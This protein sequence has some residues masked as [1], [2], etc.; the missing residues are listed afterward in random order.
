MDFLDAF[1]V[2]L[3]PGNLIFIIIGVISGIIVG[4]IPGLTAT[5]A[6]SLLLPFTFGLE[7]IPAL[8]M[9]MGIYCGSMF[10]GSITAILVRAPGT[11]GAAATAIE[12]YPLTVKGQGGK[13]IGMAAVASFI[14]GIFSAGVMIWLSPIISNFAL[15]FSYPEYFALAFFGLTIIFSVSG[16]SFLKG[17]ISGTI[18]LLLST[19]GL[20]YIIPHPRF[21]FGV[22]ELM[23]GFPLLPSVIG[24]FAVSEVFR[25]LEKS[26]EIGRITNKI[27]RTVPSLK[28]IKD[29][30]FVFLKSSIIGTL[31][32]ALPGAGA[33][34][35]SFVA[36]SEARR[37]SKQRDKYGTGVIEGIAACESAN[38]AVTGGAMIPMLTL[39]IPGDAV[40]AVLLGALTIQGLM[41]GPL[42][43]RDHLNIIRPLFAG[44]LIANIV[45]LVAG[46]A[47]ANIFARIATIRKSVLLPAIAIFSLVGAFA[48][49]S[50]IFHMGIAVGFGIMGYFLEKNGYPL[51]PI[52]L[53]IIL[54]PLAETSFRNSL[55]KSDGS[56]SI[57]FTRPISLVLIIIA[58]LSVV[59]TIYREIKAKK[60]V[61]E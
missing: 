14:G 3:Q 49:E 21:T 27:G 38:N 37:T 9:L 19:V 39:G 55:L 35:A 44:I 12:G 11:P 61:T 50:S 46:L 43:F 26:E 34:I 25:M 31:V 23:I 51:A 45:M 40:T 18:G 24:L 1:L 58:V 54:G 56:L 29:C 42:L 17:M 15:Q 60:E 59:F 48:A 6:I 52:A 32:G 41:P 10:G 53:A 30:A 22:F 28:E 16:K 57:F 33:N 4:A 13:A 7:T 47:G 5:L 2:V 20:D 8:I 36:Y